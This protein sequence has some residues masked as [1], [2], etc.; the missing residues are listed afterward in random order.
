MTE[1]NYN[2][3]QSAKNIPV[4]ESK[5][6]VEKVVEKVDKK[7]GLLSLEKGSLSK[8]DSG[9]KNH[10]ERKVSPEIKETKIEEKNLKIY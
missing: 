5:P 1:K 3:E 8:R 7:K 6:A 10:A 9:E 2:P 4:S